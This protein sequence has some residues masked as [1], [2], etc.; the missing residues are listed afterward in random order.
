[1]KKIKFFLLLLVSVLSS[2]T[3]T[4]Q[5]DDFW[6]E[7]FDE[8]LSNYNDDEY[9]VVETMVDKDKD[10]VVNLAMAY[11]D[12]ATPISEYGTG[13]GEYKYALPSDGKTEIG[14]CQ[15]WTANFFYMTKKGKNTF[16][17]YIKLWEVGSS[18]IVTE[19]GSKYLIIY[20]VDGVSFE[21]RSWYGESE[22]ADYS[23][24]SSIKFYMD[25][26][27]EAGL[28]DKMNDAFNVWG[29]FNTAVIK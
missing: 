27:Q 16:T 9:A 7:F 11:L 17:E 15:G 10:L 5:D 18:K 20:P 19:G 25:W 3:A 24:A 22:E 21:K 8:V 2:Y 23:K 14:F 4:A 13:L 26:S 6:V 29:K 12:V 28:I 1:M